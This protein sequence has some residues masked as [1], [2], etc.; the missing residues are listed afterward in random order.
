MAPKGSLILVVPCIY[1][2][3]HDCGGTHRDHWSRDGPIH[4]P[5]EILT[6][7]PKLHLV[8]PDIVIGPIED[9]DCNFDIIGGGVEDIFY[10]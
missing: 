10:C 8:D 9:G 7:E 5:P 2:H 6:L 4:N 1:I 3:L